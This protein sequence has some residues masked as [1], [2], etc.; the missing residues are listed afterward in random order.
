M[1][2]VATD[3]SHEGEHSEGCVPFFEIKEAVQRLVM[4]RVDDLPTN[5]PGEPPKSY[6]VDSVDELRL[7]RLWKTPDLCKIVSGITDHVV[8][9]LGV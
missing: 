1:Q 5:F 8:E 6:W 3:T 4:K 9:R 2:R 7:Q